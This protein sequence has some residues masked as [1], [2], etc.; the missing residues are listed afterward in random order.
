[1]LLFLCNF[2]SPRNEV[3]F[4]KKLLVVDS[5]VAQVTPYSASPITAIFDIRGLSNAIK[6]LQETCSW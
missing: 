4:L 1:M 2:L 6:P 3:D 5:F